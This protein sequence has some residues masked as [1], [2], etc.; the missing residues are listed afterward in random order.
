MWKLGFVFLKRMQNSVFVVVFSNAHKK[1][2]KFPECQSAFLDC[3]GYAEDVYISGLLSSLKSHRIWDAPWLRG[4]SGFYGSEDPSAS[5]LSSNHL[6]TI[7]II[8]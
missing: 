7:L 2:R 1:F 4:I 5:I 6:T 3:L 8:C